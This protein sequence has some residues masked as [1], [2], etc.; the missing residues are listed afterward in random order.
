MNDAV[1]MTTNQ[2]QQT[3]SFKLADD[4]LSTLLTVN[5]M[6]FPSDLTKNFKSVISTLKTHNFV[7]I[8]QAIN[9]SGN[10]KFF[11]TKHALLRV[12]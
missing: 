4:Y 6:K 12:C 5:V 2:F 11:Q 8:W 1:Q 10:I 3:I 9:I 7:Y